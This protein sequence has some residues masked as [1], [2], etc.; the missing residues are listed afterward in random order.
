MATV[1]ELL[2]KFR[3]DSSQFVANIEKAKKSVD[4]FEKSTKRSSSSI[5]DDLD[6][7][8]KKSVAIGAA[9]GT[10]IGQVAVQAFYKAGH[11]A[12]QF[13]VD[14][15]KG[16]SD[17][18]E[19]TTKTEAI[20]GSA[21]GTIMQFAEGAAT[22]IGQSKQA[23]LDAA[24]TFGI[25]GRS[26]GLSGKALTDFAMAQTKLSS[27][28]AS[29]YN[30]KPEDAAMALAAALRGQNEPARR[31]GVLIDDISLKAE[32]FK[33]GIVSST[34]EALTPQNKVLAANALIMKQT[35]VA[36]GDFAKTSEGLANQQRILAAQLENAK[37]KFG[38]A[39]LPAVL[40]VTGAF[41]TQVIPAFTKLSENFKMV[42]D[43]VSQ[44]V[45]PV[46]ANLKEV[47]SNIFTAVQPL[48]ET[49]GVGLAIAFAV[50]AKAAEILSGVIA[51][52]TGFLAENQAIL[53]VVGGA[54]A[55][56]ATALAGATI[57]FKLKTI[58]VKAA[59]AA[60]K[61]F[62]VA[63]VIMRGGQL[64]SI[65]STNGLAAS[66]LRLNAAMKAN[67]IGFV[68]G[69]IAA[70]VA[71]FVI[72]W[73]SSE[74]F[75]KIVAKAFEVVA[76]IIG[77]VVVGI[78]KV[79]KTLVN[80]WLNVAGFILKGAEKAFGWIPGIG[81]KIKDA[82]KNFQGLQNGV[83]ATFSRIID[84]AENMKKKVIT[85][86]NDAA[87]AKP[88][89]KKDKKPKDKPSPVDVP[90]I[91]TDPTDTGKAA[92]TLT[93]NLK[94]VVQD[95]KDFMASDF[96]PGF[97]KGSEAARDTILKGLDQL[98]NVFNEKAKVLKGAA[99]TKLKAAFDKA[100]NVI[101]AYIPEAMRV[102]AELEKVSKELEDAEKRLENARKER[103]SA[104]KKF[105]EVLA[106][107]FG[108]PSKITK[109]M[110]SAE[111]TVDS[112][113]S[114][115]D[116]LVE[117]V[118]QR[119]TDLAPGAR[120][121]VKEFLYA[122]TNGLIDAAR[123]RVKAIKVL[124]KAQQRLDDLLSDQKE[125]SRNITG[126]LKSFG[127]AVA[128]L[129]ETDSK[130]TISV[131]KTASGLVITQIKKSTSGV[132][133]I[134]KQLK[135]RLASITAFAANV[136]K[137]LASGLN[138]EY[139]R[140]LVEAGPEAAGTAVSALTSASSAQITEINKLYTEIGTMSDQFGATIS[141]KMYGEAIAMATA[142]RDGAA[143]G[144]ELINASMTDI[145]SN[146]SRIIGVLG[147]TGLTNAQALI[148][149]LVNEFTIM[150]EAKVGPATQIVVDKIKATIGVLAATGLANAQAFIDGLIS[151]LTGKENLSNVNLSTEA[152]KTNIDTI[153]K[154]LAPEAMTNGLGLINSL[155][156]AFGGENLTKVTASA[157][158]VKDSIKTALDT[159]RT[160]G[161]EVATD[162]AEGLYN[163][164]LAEKARL[165][166]L[167]Q[168][169]AAAIA[170]A[171]AA[172]AASIGVDVS[173]DGE[174]AD[175]VVVDEPDTTP[176][177]TTPK[178]TTPKTTT[179]KTKTPKTTTPK[180]T[181]PKGIVTPKGVFVPPSRTTPSSTIVKKAIGQNV[182]KP[183]SMP[184]FRPEVIKATTV[185]AAAPRGL[186]RQPTVIPKM[187]GS[188]TVA[189]S[190][191]PFGG[192]SAAV[193]INT[194]K[195]VSPTFAAKTV[196]KAITKATGSKRP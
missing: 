120:D 26:A 63:Q 49:L 85:A 180:T 28:L 116:E 95:Y 174:V 34:K 57:A 168:S 127:T 177:T 48:L 138:K 194:T 161:T 93:N 183:S 147:N 80:T 29:F 94:K 9:I 124:E 77:G 132:D 187:T 75:R 155:I 16:A 70:L 58:A 67:P 195:P 106:Q 134:T 6:R 179:P 12:K 89:K 4:E 23:A 44:R 64:A 113:I 52:I 31:F 47:F 104:Q 69:L 157:T 81:D 100:N 122:Q 60:I 22:S 143:L 27:D 108:E 91:P 158:A 65:A 170:A 35:S 119:F 3:A 56:F 163:K 66:M 5:G 131:I 30:T 141:E 19:S 181:T 36:Q 112:I 96:A 139:V 33:M 118:N 8:N 136:N 78:I 146:I 159:L 14:S 42:V 111:S 73:K 152:I 2:A 137:L 150:S 21:T 185:G 13:M 109:A 24:A 51:G 123:M 164:L 43:E 76:N 107:P 184:N 46:F 86:V 62:Q 171:M 105:G 172:A 186:V 140:Q 79:F 74:T 97:Q 173:G 71:G 41:N 38:Q 188:N 15:I 133:T 156:G 90:G 160:L 148:N 149:A 68:V 40:A 169:I 99:L 1:V 20:F 129:S 193:T 117:T 175:D 61:L 167:A 121:A 145:V 110:A 84:G 18:N 7:V 53:V 102:A 39:L 154:L 72:A 55:V 144:V 10:A 45:A 50:G 182:V 190:S 192:V 115:Y 92:K 189:T 83:N 126:S 151:S 11:A 98:E 17:L 37:T 114:M 103:A 162:I 165:V 135:D 142:F 196:S 178:T 88:P 32:A 25:Y 191:R 59:T 82:N 153:M 101:R 128:D 176:K 87:T 166:A 130:A 125:F 54:L